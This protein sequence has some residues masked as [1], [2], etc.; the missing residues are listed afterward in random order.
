MLG[1]HLGRYLTFLKEKSI[2]NNKI[3]DILLLFLCCILGRLNKL[4]PNICT[5]S[6]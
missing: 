6:E 1:R 2:K 5:L 4:L 3:L